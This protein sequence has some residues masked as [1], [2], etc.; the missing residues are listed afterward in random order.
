MHFYKAGGKNLVGWMEDNRLF[1]DAYYAADRDPDL[2][3][4]IAEL[5]QRYIWKHLAEIVGE[6]NACR[7][8]KERGF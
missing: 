6:D 2:K 7:I 4:E 1:M 5:E 3:T 8:M